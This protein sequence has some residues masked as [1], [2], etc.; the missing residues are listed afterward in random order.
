MELFIFLTQAVQYV[1]AHLLHF[2][3]IHI[4]YIGRLRNVRR[5]KWIGLWCKNSVFTHI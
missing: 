3:V 5:E 2:E 4:M 1:Y